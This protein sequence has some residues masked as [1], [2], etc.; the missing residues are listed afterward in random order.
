MQA[1]KSDDIRFLELPL[2]SVIPTTW[3]ACI[4]IGDRMTPSTVLD[5]A[6]S[7]DIRQ[8]VQRSGIALEREILVSKAML[9]SPRQFLDHPL[10]TILSPE[11]VSQAREKELTLFEREFNEPTQKQEIIEHLQNGL[12]VSV[13]RSLVPELLLVVDELF[14]NA[15][16]NA[17]FKGRSRTSS[18]KHDKTHLMRHMKLRPGRVFIGADTDRL[19]IGC[20]DQYGTLDPKML[21]E[22]IQ[23]CLTE[24]VLENMNF[25][26]GGAGIGSFMVYL[27]AASLYVGVDKNKRTLVCVSLPKKGCWSK[28]QVTPKNLHFF[29]LDETL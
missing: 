2:T 10:A 26:D 25:G 19:V 22:R 18:G 1:G 28:R 7:H 23:G 11:S 29:L 17:P 3:Q 20:S 13:N 15:V 24:G 4:G 27:A 14:S 6:L 21:F 8:I 9:M 5:C 16:F 12:D